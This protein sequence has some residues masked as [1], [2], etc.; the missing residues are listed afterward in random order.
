[1][2]DLH[3]NYD[4]LIKMLEIIKFKDS[5]ELYI[6]GD[7]FDKGDKSLEIF[8]YIRSHKNIILLKGNHEFMFEKYYEDNSN[9][10]LW[11]GNGGQTTHSQI[12]QRQYPFEK[13]L[14]KYIKKLPVYKVI[15]KFILVHGG[16]EFMENYNE[17]NIEN[18]LSKQDLQDCLWNR[19]NIGKEKQYKD[20]IVICGHTPVQAIAKDCNKVKIIHTTGTIYIDCGCGV[21]GK[22]GKLACLRLGDMK[23]FYV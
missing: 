3:G 6:L 23:E 21:E 18:F 20:Y 15:D 12:M 8:D 7:I 1:M 19:D 14:Y 9:L 2:S 5:D 16:L 13:N 11:Y 4:K 22:H 17:L 10:P